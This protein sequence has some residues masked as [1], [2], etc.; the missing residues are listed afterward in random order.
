MIPE[1][2]LEQAIK[3]FNLEVADDAGQINLSTKIEDIDSF[4]IISFL[5]I[6][7]QISEESS[8]KI[9]VDGITTQISEG[10][11]KSIQDLML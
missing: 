5:V 4:S 3:Q 9:E 11:I 1:K 2:I 6:L 8:T 10:K 7:E